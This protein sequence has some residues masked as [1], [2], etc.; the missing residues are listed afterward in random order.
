M[1][2][3]RRA[4]A[5]LVALTVVT[6][7]CG[8]DTDA[9]P[10]PSEGPSP[11]PPRTPAPT[12]IA[13]APAS[14]PATGSACDTE[15]YAGRLGRIEALD[16]RTVRFTLCR[17]DAAFPARLGHPAL[18]VLD[19]TSIARLGEDR[20]ASTALAGTGPYRI[21]RWVDDDNVQLARVGEATDT[22]TAE[23]VIIRWNEDAAAR[24]SQLQEAAVDGID[25][26]GPAQLQEIATLPEL[27]VTPRDGLATAFL[28]FG[29]GPAFAGTR[30][31]RAIAGSLDR[32]TL[33]ATALPEGSRLATHVT[34]C[35][36]ANGCKGR[37]WYGF[38][39]PA[40]VAALDA[41]SFDRS[42]TYPLHVPDAPVPGLPDPAGLAEAIRAQLAGNIGLEVEIDVMPLE[43]FR[44]AAD[45][46]RLD[47]LYLDG[48]ATSLADPSGFLE[49]LFGA[50]V[51]TTPARRAS[52]VRPA[53]AE[54]SATTDPEGRAAAI[55]EANAEIRSAAVIVPIGH[56]GSVVAYR[57]DVEGV[58][59]SPLGR[60]PIGAATPGDRPQ[61]VFMQET[62]P[63]GAWCGDQTSFDAYR[64][65]GLLGEG[66]YG[67]GT[68]ELSP[69][70]RLADC[71][72]DRT[73]RTW[74]CALRGEPTFTDG[75]RVDAGDV[76]ATYG[77]LWDGDGAMRR[78][79]PDGA[80]AAWD[81]LFG[82]PLDADG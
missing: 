73:A 45:A 50:G 62:P 8:G 80:F 19:A 34:P 67:F 43:A 72:P 33:T 53:L 48:V 61:L 59:T 57:N 71:E 74:T 77:A 42:R 14:L 25:T 13:F 68:G 69:E 26:P 70:P 46:G 32:E 65:C 44:E 60:D 21:E 66:L 82:A 7:A 6:A 22:A 51:R 4:V 24:A 16:A 63:A 49:P 15:G 2:I 52:D 37:P 54:A 41:A 11:T 36:V 38:N 18:G 27:V 35:I 75:M 30:V 23:T 64:L 76:L 81:E 47:G 79:S 3:P 58:A 55:E 12:E 28:A 5:V 31:R 29:S 1:S 17:P 56:P 39:A 40:A 10:A 9:T 20:A 78:G